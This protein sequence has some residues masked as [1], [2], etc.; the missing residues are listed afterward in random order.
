MKTRTVSLLVV[1][2]VGLFT[3]CGAGDGDGAGLLSGPMDI[4]DAATVSDGASPTID[5][6]GTDGTSTADADGTDPDASSSGDAFGTDASS[7]DT[8]GSSP[9]PDAGEPEAGAVCQ[10]NARACNG[11]APLVCENGTW[12]AEPACTG[13]TPVCD[14]GLCVACTTGQKQCVSLTPRAC[15][16]GQWQYQTACGGGNPVCL[17]GTCVQ[18]VPNDKRCTGSTPQLCSN[19]GTWQDQPECVGATPVCLPASA[20]CVECNSGDKKCD[21]PGGLASYACDGTN[22]WTKTAT[23]QHV[24]GPTTK[25]CGVCQPNAVRCNASQGQTCDLDGLW[26]TQGSCDPACML[27]AGRLTVNYD[28]KTVTDTTTGLKWERFP[29]SDQMNYAAA[30][31]YCSNLVLGGGQWRLPTYDE[32]VSLRLPDQEVLCQ[33][34]VDQ[35]AFPALQTAIV[36]TT[37]SIQAGTHRTANLFPYAIPSQAAPDTSDNYTVICVK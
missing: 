28:E 32:I 16:A 35:V 18:C 15:V 20:T 33:P 9:G 26:V 12:S 14:Q 22:T 10:A 27:P 3:A 36:W 25:Q 13:S 31:T 37:T 30:S 4:L 11:A 7:S 24:C 17:D 34:Y 29:K 8:D 2:L 21:G 5:E 6:A 19:N 23:C 1:V